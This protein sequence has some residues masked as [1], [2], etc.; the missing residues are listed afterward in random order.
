MFNGAALAFAHPKMADDQWLLMF[1]LQ[2]EHGALPDAVSDQWL[3]YNF[4]KPPVQGLLY[5]WTQRLHPGYWNAERN[6]WFYEHTAAFTCWWLSHR[7]FPGRRLCHYLHGNDSGWDNTT[8]LR[9]GA[10][11]ESPD[12]NS[13]LIW[14]CRILAD[15]AY[16]AGD[17]G[18]A[19]DWQAVADELQAALLE[20][21]WDGNRFTGYLPMAEKVVAA[22][23]LVTL[24][25][26]VLGQS[27]PVE[28]RA[29]LLT[30]LDDCLTEFGPATEMPTSEFYQ[31]DG[32]WR[33]PIW[34]PSTLLIVH[35][36]MAS[37]EIKRSREVALRFLRLC[38]MSG[39]AENFDA[40]TGAPLRD[41]NYTWTAS[42]FLELAAFVQDMDAQRGPALC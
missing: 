39:F 31:A 33:G 15:L 7:R 30:Q 21:L 19:Q 11:I 29:A 2:D 41:L 42:A 14:Q 6:D 17:R 13:F 38:E 4:S 27:L 37:G 23:S 3:H 9:E 32:Y 28:V 40:L 20:E 1:E 10:P 35:G 16:E 18:A 24:M 5:S 22:Q 34:G 26:L 25:P 8:L 36:L 12:L